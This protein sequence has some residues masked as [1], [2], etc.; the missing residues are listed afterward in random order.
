MLHSLQL[1]YK[2]FQVSL[3]IHEYVLI[4]FRFIHYFLV[5][6]ELGY[7]A[8]FSNIF[9]GS[10]LNSPIKDS[11]TILPLNFT[12]WRSKNEEDIYIYRIYCINHKNINNV[13]FKIYIALVQ[14]K[15]DQNDTNMTRNSFS[16]TDYVIIKVLI[17]HGV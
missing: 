6:V 15:W 11:P 12:Q 17:K 7:L 8:W 13:P 5:L 4:D 16:T 9:C 14:V 2:V 1:V 3:S 10:C